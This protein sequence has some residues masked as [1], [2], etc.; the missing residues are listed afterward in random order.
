MAT[1]GETFHAR[2]RKAWRRWLEQNHATR[3]EIWLLFFKK[4][5]A[6]SGVSYGEAVEEAL[7]FG[8]IDGR[9]QSIDSDRHAYRFTPRKPDSGWSEL[10]KRRV[11]QLVVEGRMTPAGQALVDLAHQT[12]RW[13]ASTKPVVPEDF[14]EDL[15]TAL[16]ANR[17]ARTY[18]DGL[19]PSHRRAYLAWLTAA[20]RP[21]TRDKRVHE[22]VARCAAGRKP[23]IDL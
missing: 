21:A 11:A 23:G 7:C 20:K 4:H 22:I 9:I 15:A 6:I 18:F 10:N 3:P 12:G 8:W 13:T 2:D 5:A 1:I 14:P 17:A 19:A 16:D